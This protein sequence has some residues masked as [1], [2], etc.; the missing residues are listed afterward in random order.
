M[1]NDIDYAIQTVLHTGKHSLV[2]RAHSVKD[3]KN[4]ILK[5]LHSDFPVLEDVAKLQHEYHIL[6]QIK[7]DGVVRVH[8]F[9]KTKNK[10]AIVLE[11]LEGES[12][13]VFLKNSP[14]SLDVF[15]TIT[16]QLIDILGTLHA[17]RIIHKDIK[18]SN[19]IINPPTLKITVID[20]SVSSQFSQEM[21]DNLHPN[22]LQGTLAYMSPEQT[23]RMN[24]SVDYRADFYSLGITLY[25]ML[26]GELP[27]KNQ[28]PLELIHCHLAKT[29][30]SVSTMNPE[31]P[32]PLS[33]VIDK[34]ISKMPEE[35]YMSV[36]GL[37]RDM[38]EC[39]RQWKANHQIK[40]FQIGLQD[41]PD[42]LI[43]AQ[44]LFGREQELNQLML[45]FER[46][47]HG[48]AQLLLVSG[49]SGI[50]KTSLVKEIYKPIAYKLGYFFSG[51][52]D[53]LNRTI[54]YSAFIEAFARLVH[55]LLSEPEDVI[56]QIK[57]KILECVGS[58]G[59]IIIDVIPAIKAIIGTQ[60]KLP[61]LPP[62]EARNRF[63]L[64]FQN[65]VR[66][67]AQANHP[68]VLF[69]DDWQWADDASLQLLKSLLTDSSTSNLL[70]ICAYRSN[71]TPLDHPFTLAIQALEKNNIALHNITLGPLKQHDIQQL[72]AASL[73]CSMDKVKE[74][75][76]L[77]NKKTQGNPFFINEF[78][79]TLYQN[80]LLVFSYSQMAWQ[81][82]INA[83]KK[84]QST[85]NVIDLLRYRLDKLSED[86]QNI[87]KLAACMG[88]IFDIQKLALISQTPLNKLA[89][90][91]YQAIEENLLL[92]VED[93]YL[94]IETLANEQ[95]N[96]LK[97][98]EKIMCRFV[99]D[100]VQQASYNLIPIEEKQQF[101][102]PHR[103]HSSRAL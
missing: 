101:P 3:R 59:Q 49:Y 46:S 56:E 81:W 22:S 54:A 86:L 80:R 20:F 82:D 92:P 52:F 103:L 98:S 69:I 4:V 102:P 62:I 55:Q 58:N 79:K 25:Q 67:F 61:V 41:I 9:I 10:L 68:L 14:V 63:T 5:V 89:Q 97:T 32:L 37:K 35:R 64:T 84:T 83:I 53:L 30:V 38:A 13:E 18:P 42:N 94:L 44:K 31:I 33:L 27:F 24:H 11:D 40:D 100:R 12:L 43:I 47:R 72:L 85:E 90:L 8:D 96:H 71:E 60:P 6:Q 16:L 77:I 66:V 87:I 48:H 73:S 29:P 26:V 65:F 45:A 1:T 57:R 17:D 15:F 19:I 39:A 91:L 75:A 51:K 70:I 28:D 93:S 50:G 7:S 34:L 99:H 2:C 74:L 23:G 76:L 36:G 95:K 88:H 21:R 78:L